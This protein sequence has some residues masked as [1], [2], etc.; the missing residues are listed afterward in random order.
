MRENSFHPEML[1]GKRRTTASIRTC[2]PGNAGQ[3]LPSGDAA[4][5]TP[6]NS[7][8]PQLLPGKRRTT[9]SIRRCN[10]SLYFP[11]SRLQIVKLGSGEAEDNLRGS[12]ITLDF[13][14]PIRAD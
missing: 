4:R 11:R 13:R 10:A 14:W 8:H 9:A 7:F 6:D 5:E 12:A 2:C 1:P 3:Q